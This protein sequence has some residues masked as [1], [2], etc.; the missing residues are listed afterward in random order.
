MVLKRPV[1]KAKLGLLLTLILVGGIL[2]VF[3][4]AGLSAGRESIHPTSVI[5]ARL[6]FAG[7]G[8]WC[9]GYILSLI[10]LHRMWSIIQDGHARTTAGK[11]VGFLFIPFYSL[12]WAFQAYWGLAVDYNR[13]IARHQVELQRLPEGL[14][15]AFSILNILFY[16]PFVNLLTIPAMWII[17]MILY[18]YICNVINAFS[19]PLDETAT[20]APVRAPQYH[21]EEPVGEP[22]PLSKSKKLPVWAVVVISSIGG[23]FLLG[24]IA[25]IAIPNFVAYKKRALETATVSETNRLW[26]G[27]WRT[28]GPLEPPLYYNCLNIKF[29]GNFPSLEWYYD[30]KDKRNVITTKDVLWDDASIKFITVASGNEVS[31]KLKLEDPGTIHDDICYLNGEKA[32]KKLTA[33]WKKT[34]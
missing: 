1:K 5:L 14:L 8:I 27:E 22:P 31:H 11:A 16:I 12:Y 24:L 13:F 20:P 2:S 17:S 9:W 15:L 3:I 33:K 29:Q 6:G 30:Y 18:S 23:L 26:I 32:G 10:Y 4:S 19:E 7:F 34:K 21:P 25:A 28:P